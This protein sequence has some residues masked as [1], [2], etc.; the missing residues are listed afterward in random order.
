[1]LQYYKSYWKIVGDQIGELSDELKTLYLKMVAFNEKKRPNID[2]I[3]SD[4][5][6]K[7]INDLNEIEYKILEKEVIQEFET[8]KTKI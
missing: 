5:W 4:P 2:E 8:L 3:L 7:E 1:M 6:M